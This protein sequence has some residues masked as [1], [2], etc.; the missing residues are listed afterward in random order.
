MRDSADAPARFHTLFA[1]SAG[2][3]PATLQMSGADEGMLLPS[4]PHLLDVSGPVLAAWCGTAEPAA[5][6]PR[7]SACYIEHTR[8][9]RRQGRNNTADLRASNRNLYR[10]GLAR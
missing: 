10:S 2:R 5:R 4:L 1:A 7:S 8:R 3:C 6:G 9:G